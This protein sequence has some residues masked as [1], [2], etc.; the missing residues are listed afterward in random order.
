M[1]YPSVRL[2]GLNLPPATYTGPHPPPKAPLPPGPD[3]SGGSWEVE[4]GVGVRAPCPPDAPSWVALDLDVPL[5]RHRRGIREV[6]G[7]RVCTQ[8]GD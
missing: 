6:V 3:G 1:S 5:R 7:A 8:G 4:A 2:P